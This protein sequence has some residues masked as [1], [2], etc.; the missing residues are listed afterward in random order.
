MHLLKL[1]WLAFQILQRSTIHDHKQAARC[2]FQAF[3]HEA[4]WQYVSPG[5]YLKGASRPLSSWSSA[6]HPQ[7]L[8]THLSRD[9]LCWDLAMAFLQAQLSPC[10]ESSPS[11]KHSKCWHRD[12]VE[13]WRWEKSVPTFLVR[14]S[15]YHGAMIYF[16]PTPAFN[17][18]K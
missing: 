18:E 4:Y 15:N 3:V 9:L 8:P 5:W 13:R 6:T 10:P 7:T 2:R 1:E 16:K 17:L 12:M 11:C 14:T